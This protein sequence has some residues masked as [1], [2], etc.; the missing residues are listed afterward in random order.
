[1]SQSYIYTNWRG[2]SFIIDEKFAAEFWIYMVE[3]GIRYS[4]LPHGG[5]TSYG[6]MATSL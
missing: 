5:I 1:M 3:D 4:T 2:K 6:K